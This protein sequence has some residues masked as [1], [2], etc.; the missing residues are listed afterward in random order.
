MGQLPRQIEVLREV[1]RSRQLRRLELSWASYYTCEWAHFVAISVYAYDRGGAPAVGIFGLVRMLAAAAAAPFGSILADRYSRKRLQIALHAARAVFLAGVVAALSIGAPTAVVFAIAG[2]ASLCGG[3]FRPAYLALIPSLARTAQELVAANVSSSAFEGA[4]VLIGP[5]VAGGVLTVAS[6]AVVV[7]LSAG[8]SLLAAAL[9]AGVGAE[10]WRPPSRL[11]GWTALG[12]T[13]AGLQTLRAEPNPRLIVA[14]FGA[15]SFVRGLLNVLLVAASIRYL[16]SGRSG[17]GFL[18]SAL[19][20]GGLAGG[21]VALSVVHRRR[22]AGPFALGLVLWGAPIAA[23]A[24]WPTFAWA[25]LCIAVVG[26]GNALLDVS[27]Y[28]LVQRTVEDRVLGRVFGVFEVVASGSVGI[29]S[30]VAPLLLSELSVRDSLI[31]SGSLLPVLAILCRPR[32]REIDDSVVVREEEFRLLSGLSI[33]A[34]LPVATLEKLA[35]RLIPLAAPAG[36]RIVEQKDVGDLFY[37]IRSG[38]VTVVCD[39]EP[40]SEQG[41]GDYFGEIALLRDVP[42]TATC[43]AATDVELFALERS[44][45]VSAVTGHVRTSATAEDVMSERL[46]EP[47]RSAR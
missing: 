34:P 30:I 11:P 1:F 40:V 4:A 39:G 3:P 12:E 33:F 2:L 35:A 31:V 20:I 28:S 15:Q 46:G 47:E 38:T 27:G 8:I 32:L 14:L 17:V 13:L 21:L 26:A 18:T 42:R 10:D 25:A 5:V 44:A 6:P 16:G 29:G 41:P 43:V 36:T 24:A 45:F 37:L 23:V 9:V 22:L 19:G 7:A